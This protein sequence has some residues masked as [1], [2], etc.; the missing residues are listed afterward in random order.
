ME[1]LEVI[2]YY[3]RLFPL[4][5]KSLNAF[6]SSTRNMIEQVDLYIECFIQHYPTFAI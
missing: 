3:G 2:E 4:T 5:T 6:N 1:S